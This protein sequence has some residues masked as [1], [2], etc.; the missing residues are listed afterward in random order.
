MNA[1]EL[2]YENTNFRIL[3]LGS[4]EKVD[5][6]AKRILLQTKATRRTGCANRK[7]YVVK[8]HDAIGNFFLPSNVKWPVQQQSGT[9]NAFLYISPPFCLFV[10]QTTKTIFR[11]GCA[12]GSPIK[13]LQLE[14]YL[15]QQLFPPANGVAAKFVSP[16]KLTFLV[17]CGTQMTFVPE[18]VAN[19]KE[20]AISLFPLLP[21]IPYVT[22][23]T[24]SPRQDQNHPCV[25]H[26]DVLFLNSV[27]VTDVM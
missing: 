19:S 6:Q 3:Q 16:A 25:I 24:S 1:R 14:Q 20:Q 8:N 4:R 18:N 27:T 2:L 22:H 9:R 15:Q 17:K 26:V 10:A 13:R 21:L 12:T 11:L 23:V 7:K 5:M